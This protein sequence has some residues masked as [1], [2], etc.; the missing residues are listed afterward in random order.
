MA[1]PTISAVS[2][3]IAPTGGQVLIEITGTNFRLHDA[4]PATGA[5]PTP[6]F[7]T[8]QVEFGG[9]IAEY[10]EAA[11][12][13]TIL[14]T[15]PIHD[16][17]TVD[18]IVRNLDN[19]GVAIPTEEVTSAAAF[20]FNRPDILGQVSRTE[21]VTKQ[22]ILELRRQV[23]AEV[24][25]ARHTDWTD[26]A[27]DAVRETRIAKLPS[28]LVVGPTMTTDNF[29]RRPTMSREYV[30]DS[31]VGF[32]RPPTT[33]ELGFDVGVVSDHQAQV[34]RITDALISFFNR[35]VWLRALCD[36]NDSASGEVRYEMGYTVSLPKFGQ[37]PKSSNIYTSLGTVRVRGVD[38]GLLPGFTDDL[39][40]RRSAVLPV[41]PAITIAGIDP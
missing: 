12:A 5:V 32:R 37:G 2:P 22:L 20:T 16:P 35:N 11:S 27:D 8:V 3:A 39:I 25:L 40:T 31:N 13:T 41:V 4:P 21:H 7:S 33:V 14:A 17:G 6:Q 36:Q 34:M 19:L 38:L 29:F 15:A 18:I 26:D 10:A 30:S 1:I 28:I 9:V 24:V 23:L